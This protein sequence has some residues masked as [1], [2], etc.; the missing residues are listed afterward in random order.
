MKLEAGKY[1]K[2]RVGD[3]VEMIG[4]SVHN[5]THPWI[6]FIGNEEATWKDDGTHYTKPNGNDIVGEWKEL[7]VCTETMYLH[8]F[9]GGND[10]RMYINRDPNEALGS[11]IVTIEEG[12]FA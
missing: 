9:A 5:L 7:R 3:R 6:G 1:Y 2:T 11:G 8:S 12:E 10:D 4:K